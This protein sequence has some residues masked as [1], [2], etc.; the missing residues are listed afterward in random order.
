MKTVLFSAALLSLSVSAANADDYLSGYI[1]FDYSHMRTIGDASGARYFDESRD[2]AT[3]TG[4][5]QY[6]LNNCAVGLQIS[7]SRS[8]T[9]GTDYAFLSSFPYEY[10]SNGYVAGAEAGCRV[11]NLWIIGLG[12]L[13]STHSEDTNGFTFDQKMSGYGAGLY[14][15]FNN[16]YALGFAAEKVQYT[17]SSVNGSLDFDEMRYLAKS[18]YFF[19][20]NLLWSTT[21]AFD[22]FDTSKD[23]SIFSRI[24][25]KL[26]NHPISFYAGIGGTWLKA[27]DFDLTQKGLTAMIGAR[28][29][30]NDG[31]LKT[32]VGN[33]I[34]NFGN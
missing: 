14:Y 20:D 29:Y 26:K 4:A 31:S 19:N 34:P 15:I 28:F 25:Y 33:S 22:H 7:G 9:T 32:I 10:D 30:F 21:L 8:H 2:A 23:Y 1:D 6:R 18:D 5:F 3:L 12:S 11:Q 27:N 17:D 16:N 13:G 24:E